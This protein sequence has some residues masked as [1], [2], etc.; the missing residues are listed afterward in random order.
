MKDGHERKGRVQVGERMP[1]SGAPPRCPP[2]CLGLA[3]AV[4][5]I[6]GTDKR[7]SAPALEHR[8]QHYF[9]CCGKL[10]AENA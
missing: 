10:L 1:A 4:H 7:F 3:Y 9:N 8:L 2:E 6:S 5:T